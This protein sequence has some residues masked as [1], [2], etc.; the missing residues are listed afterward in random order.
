[1]GL[2]QRDTPK[3]VD[4]NTVGVVVS[5]IGLMV[6]IDWHIL[7]NSFFS[8]VRVKVQCKDPTK[9]PRKRIFVFKGGL[10][11]IRFKTEDFVQ[12]ENY[13]DDDNDPDAGVEELEND[14]DD[15]LGDDP[16]DTSTKNGEN[17]KSGEDNGSKGGKETITVNETQGSKSAPAR[18]KSAKRVLLFEDDDPKEALKCVDLLRAMELEGD[19]SEDED[20]TLNINEMLQDDNEQVSLPD[21]WIYDLQQK[22]LG[23]IVE[24]EGEASLI[25]MEG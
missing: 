19:E 20:V 11:L 5:S 22:K 9:V 18:G 2:G 3:W 16:N 6:E 1:M 10:Y 17:S 12:I 7:F 25:S 8:M 15:L 23:E 21:E 13:S 24:V 4:W 14:D